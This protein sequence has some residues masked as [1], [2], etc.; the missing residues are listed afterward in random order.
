MEN[1]REAL[2]LQSADDRPIAWVRFN[3]DEADGQT[4]GTVAAQR[5]RCARAVEIVRDLLSNPRSCTEYVN[6]PIC[7]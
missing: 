3:P 1:V 6:Y 2:L 4:R 7:V 5:R